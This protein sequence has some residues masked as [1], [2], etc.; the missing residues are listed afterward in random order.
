MTET[1]LDEDKIK[2]S[3]NNENKTKKNKQPI[4]I[5]EREKK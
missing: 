5:Q 3:Q 2:N 1:V 4:N